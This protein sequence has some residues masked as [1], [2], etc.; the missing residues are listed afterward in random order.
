MEFIQNH[1]EL[2]CL[3]GGAIVGVILPKAK[4]NLFGQ[5]VGQKIPRKV[6]IAIAD[7]IDAF[8]KGMRQQ[9]VNGDNSIV[10]N[11]QLLKGTESLKINLGLDQKS[12][13]KASR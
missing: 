6:A 4:A 13:E 8:E 10:S 2:I 3:I 11:E 12:K 9:D 1:I 7:Q 5:K